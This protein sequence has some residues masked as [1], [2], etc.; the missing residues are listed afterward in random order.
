MKWSSRRQLTYLFVIVFFL[1][2][3]VGLVYLIYKPE[4][5]C[6]DGIKNQG[7]EDVDCGGPCALVCKKNAL[8]LK[9]YWARVFGLKDNLY[10]AA[11]LV[12]NENPNLGVK[13]LQYEFQL[14]D[15]NNVLLVKRKGET[16]VNPGE[17][18]VIFE[19]NI[20]SSQTYQATKAFIEIQ[21]S[22]AWEKTPTVPRVISIERIGFN[23]EPFPTLHLNVK[24][25]SFDN[26]RQIKI[27]SVL[28]DQ[29]QNAFAAS[30]TFIDEL[31]AGE[32]KEVF[33]TWPKSFEVEPSYVDNFW[34]INSF[35]LE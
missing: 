3:L 9:T 18:F 10:D 30:A 4:P 27:S 2:I 15:S 28:S 33:L 31:L 32:K 35:D 24:N 17:K 13:N 7:E 14:F 21:E 29:N 5:S 34:R 1:A 11:A 20:E 16:F 23:N 26:Y 6:F 8:P 25:N 19:S 22:P 12:E